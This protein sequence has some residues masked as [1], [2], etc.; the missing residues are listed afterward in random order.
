[1]THNEA[2]QKLI[3]H[4]DEEI[5]K[6]GFWIF[7]RKELH[8]DTC[9]ILE[10]YEKEAN[11]PLPEKLT[12]RGIHIDRTGIDYGD[13]KPLAWDKIAAAGIKSEPLYQEH[14]LTEYIRHLLLCLHTGEIIVIAIGNIDHLKGLFGHFIA[15]YKADAD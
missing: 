14:Q 2:R 3:D 8:F 1:M 4:C 13:G 7:N 6:S 15:S 10:P 12:V 11:L 9:R 5:R